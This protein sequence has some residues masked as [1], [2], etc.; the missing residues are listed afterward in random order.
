MTKIE[1]LEKVTNL[2]IDKAN[3]DK[4]L[5]WVKV[6]PR[7]GASSKP[8][9]N[10]KGDVHMHPI[11]GHPYVLLAKKNGYWVCCLMTSESTCSEILEPCESRFYPVNFITKTL[12][13]VNVPVGSFMSVYENNKQLASIYS[14]LKSIF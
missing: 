1:L 10:K 13:T 14:K 2:P 6:L 11:F 8:V 3:K 9:R 5:G 12:I 7:D 4:I